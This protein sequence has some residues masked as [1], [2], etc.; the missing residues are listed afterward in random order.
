MMTEMEEYGNV[1]VVKEILTD[2]SEVFNVV[3]D[4]LTIQCV[5]ENGANN[6]AAVIYHSA[7][8]YTFNVKR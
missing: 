6:I 4:E 2:N 1:K 5:D 3:W 8:G 7:V